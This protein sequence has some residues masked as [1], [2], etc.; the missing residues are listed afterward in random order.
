LN[1]PHV[2]LLLNHLP[3]IG[4]F[5]AFALF[6]VS[7]IGHRHDLRQ[8][9]LALFALIALLAIPTYMSGDAAREALKDSPD[10]SMDLIQT[11]QGAAFLAFVFMEITGGFALIGLWPFSRKEEK[12]HWTSSPE[13][14]NLAAV[15]LFAIV[16]MGLMAIAGNTGG[17]IR[18]PEIFSDQDTASTVGAAGARIVTFI[19]HIV[20]DTSMWVWPILEDLHFLGLILL[21]GATGAFNL[22]ILGFFKQL[23]VAPLHRFI[24]WGIAGFIVNIITGIFFFMGMPGF[25]TPNIVFQLKMFTIAIA[26]GS[27]LLFYCT[28][29]FRALEHLGPGDDA[30][31]VAKCI[32]AVTLF[33]WIF[34]IVLGRYIPF[35][36]VT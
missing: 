10:L 26:G 14:W 4:T 6:F 1:L 5:I 29:A 36:E 27:L 2:H 34:V 24:P 31:F 13:R 22:R 18:H 35:G 15:L 23:P 3:I 32:A 33:L 7:L 16:T 21:I 20:I 12:S 11:H 17:A 25:Y 19:H 30:P 9:S 28:S 8:A